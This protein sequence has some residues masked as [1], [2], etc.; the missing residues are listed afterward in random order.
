M[1]KADQCPGS[2]RHRRRHSGVCPNE[3]AVRGP[4][5][6][7][8]TSIGS[9]LTDP[10]RPGCSLP[11]GL[12]TEISGVRHAGGS[13][14][15]TICGKKSVL[16]RRPRQKAFKASSGAWK[17]CALYQSRWWCVTERGSSRSHTINDP[18]G[19]G[20][21]MRNVPPSLAPVRTRLR[22]YRDDFVLVRY[23]RPTLSHKT[24]CL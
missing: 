2:D 17:T 21:A 4:R 24:L 15:S 7:T 19:R 5:F 10:S 12:I 14:R 9:W 8:N 11:A 18:P 22:P 3:T 16:Q 23:H 20:Q 6:E 13:D 1:R